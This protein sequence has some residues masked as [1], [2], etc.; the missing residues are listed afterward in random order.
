MIRT[1]DFNNLATGETVTSQY[2]DIG[3]TV[4]ATAV[5]TGSD[6]A[7][8]F[9]TNNPTGEDDDLATTNL[10]NV[11]IVSEDGDATDPDD[12]AKGGTFSFKFDDEVTVKSLTFLDIEAPARMRFYGEEGTLI[13]EQ[14]VL[15]TGDNGQSVIQ[16]FVPG[17]VRFEIDLTSSGAI[18]DLVFDDNQPEV[19]LDGIVSGDD[20]ADLIDLAYTG[21]PDGD[22]IDAGDAVIAGEAAD[23]DIVDA[24]G[25]NDTITSLEG[26][27]DVYAGSGDDVVSGGEGDDLIYGDTTLAD[28]DAVDSVEQ[29]RESFNWS[30]AG[31]EN[32]ETIDGFTQDTGNVNVTFTNLGGTAKTETTFSTD[33]QR[34]DGIEGEDEAVSST[35]SLSSVTRADGQSEEYQLKIKN[36]K[37]P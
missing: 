30:S 36:K 2:E 22:R 29:T 13:S 20:D 18:D 35:S 37:I 24:L 4:F 25:G 23:D 34:V 3:L 7:M 16:L 27:D 1:V 12:N 5:G 33:T 28:K 8:I 31:L 15:P 10:D 11:L 6:Q 9:D 17:T 26:D 32:G 19:V 14:T 21:D